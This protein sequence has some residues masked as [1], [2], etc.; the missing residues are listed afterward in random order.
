M[1]PAS[2]GRGVKACRLWKSD[3]YL[4]L[5]AASTDARDFVPYSDPASNEMT[6]WA[7]H[8]AAQSIW[9]ESNIFLSLMHRLLC[10]WSKGGA[11]AKE[12]GKWRSFSDDDSNYDS[13][14]DD[15]GRA[16][17]LSLIFHFI[18]S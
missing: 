15:K 3:D 7:H 8:P 2:E 18:Q 10:F 16:L 13:D 9:Y 12:G 4:N 5:K 11:L 14:D 1:N 17:V 6:V